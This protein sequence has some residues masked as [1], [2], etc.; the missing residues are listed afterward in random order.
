MQQPSGRSRVACLRL[1]WSHT[2][3]FHKIK[4]GTVALSE[5]VADNEAVTEAIS[6]EAVIEAVIQV[7]AL[8]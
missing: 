6:T 8:R 7:V 1:F 4:S 5:S 2:Q 3:T